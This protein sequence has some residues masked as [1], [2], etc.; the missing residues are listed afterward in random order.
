MESVLTVN[1]TNRNLAAKVTKAQISKLLFYF[2]LFNS[3]DYFNSA[4][5]CKSGLIQMENNITIMNSQYT[6]KS[7]C[8]C[9]LASYLLTSASLLAWLKCF[10]K[11]H[12][13]VFVEKHSKIPL[14]SWCL[15]LP[16][17]YPTL[18]FMFMC[19]VMFYI[20]IL[21]DTVS[22]LV[23]ALINYFHYFT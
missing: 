12:K 21:I 7:I 15:Q 5:M 17:K 4:F 13:F 10:K 18:H 8:W 1:A 19:D 16:W 23:F 22:L 14:V 2:N 6:D 11:Y 20:F 3:R 9:N